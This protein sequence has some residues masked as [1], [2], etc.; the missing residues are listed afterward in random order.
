MAR[1]GT[2]G[3][4]ATRPSGGGATALKQSSLQSLSR[5]GSKCVVLLEAWGTRE[6]TWEE[7]RGTGSFSPSSM[8]AK[9]VGYH[10]GTGKEGRGRPCDSWGEVEAH[11]ESNCGG[12]VVGE[13]ACPANS[14]TATCGSSETMTKIAMASGLI[15][16]PASPDRRR[17]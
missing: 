3:T 4:S 8:A 14:S 1:G 6:T 11:P 17:R 9:L 10:C 12:G 2:G 7:R 16:T 13:A 15:R 5:H